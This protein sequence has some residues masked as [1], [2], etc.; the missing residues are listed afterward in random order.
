[1]YRVTSY[2]HVSRFLKTRV[3]SITYFLTYDMHFLSNI[4]LLKIEIYIIIE[5]M[6]KQQF[7]LL[8]PFPG[9]SETKLVHAAHM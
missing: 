1:M 4:H 3:W 7:L 2:L 6:W 8:M 9:E 5:G